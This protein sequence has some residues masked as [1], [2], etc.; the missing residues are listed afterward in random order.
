[1]VYHRPVYSDA[2]GIST[3]VYDNIERKYRTTL[4]KTNLRSDRGDLRLYTF[5]G[6]HLHGGAPAAERP[7]ATKLK[8][9]K[10]IDL[11]A[12]L[13]D[14]PYVR[15][16]F[17]DHL[18]ATTPEPKKRSPRS[19]PLM[20][21]PLD[22]STGPR[23]VT[24]D[25]EYKTL[26]TRFDYLESELKKPMTKTTTTVTERWVPLTTY[27]YHT[28]FH[29]YYYKSTPYM[30][31]TYRTADDLYSYDYLDDYKRYATTTTKTTTKNID[32]LDLSTT[33]KFDYSSYAEKW[34][35]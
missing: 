12:P 13:S 28:P 25:S 2:Y 16:G 29:S 31:Y 34:Y 3:P 32:A 20:D 11:Y 10:N 35:V 27:I 22:Y 18:R 1:M 19:A 17:Y 5:A 24:A 23:K 4:S 6:S 33:T 14:T 9:N 8:G 21:D 30:S 26:G 15:G 7:M